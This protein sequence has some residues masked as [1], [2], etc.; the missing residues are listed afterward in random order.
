MFDGEL[1]RSQL[2]YAA[3]RHPKQRDAPVVAG[4]DWERGDGAVAGVRVLRL[5][6]RD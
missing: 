6:T 2:G 5:V 4:V 1:K 3:I